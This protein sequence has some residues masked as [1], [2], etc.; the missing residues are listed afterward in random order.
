MKKD[1]IAHCDVVNGRL[2]WK[3]EDYMRV[4]LP[5]FE[6]MKGVLQVK[7]KWNKRS[8]SQ[9]ALYW[10]R[11]GVIS[12]HTGHTENELHT[13]YKGS[14]APKKEIT[15]KT[16]TYTLPKGTSEMSK[17]EMAE[18]MLHIEAEAEQLGIVLPSPEDL[19][20]PILINK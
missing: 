19:D 10:L 9:N 14:Y 6:G 3:S 5:L 1:F 8:L 7:A 13:L 15:Y 17:G 18:F 2:V 4:N 12:E 11:L 20:R 16:R